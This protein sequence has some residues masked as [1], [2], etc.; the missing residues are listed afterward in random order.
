MTTR[1]LYIGGAGRSGSTLL[2][3]I[4]AQSP[5]ATT[6]GE[7]V[8]LARNRLHAGELCGCGRRLL[9]CERWSLA[10]NDSPTEFSN[11]LASVQALDARVNRQRFIPSLIAGWPPSYQR[12][13]DQYVKGLAALYREVAQREGARFIVDASKWPSFAYAAARSPDIDLRLVHLVRDPRAV[14]FSWTKS[15]KVRP[16]AE[17]GAGLRVMRTYG[18]VRSARDWLAFNSAFE[19][20]AR[21]VPSVC[22]RYEELA[23]DGASALFK[24]GQVIEDWLPSGWDFSDILVGHNEVTL[25][26][27]HGLAGNPMRFQSGRVRLRL[28]E[29]WR[30]GLP[31]RDRKKVE[32]VAFPLMV[33]YGMM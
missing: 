30:A 7:F 12:D 8:E 19:V 28:D 20:L 3:R 18:P 11:H 14:A 33:R 5:G 31:K 21:R 24:I 2:E 32:A 23:T 15:D 9:D 1:V 16:H 26:P 10:F 13:A 27:S 29:S 6:V 4:L 17:M 25:T 22:T